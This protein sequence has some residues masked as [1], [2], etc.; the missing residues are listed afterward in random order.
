MG[1]FTGPSKSISFQ[2]GSGNN[3]NDLGSG[4]LTANSGPGAVMNEAGQR[5]DLWSVHKSG[6]TNFRD[7]PPYYVM[8][9]ATLLM[10]FRW[11]TVR[12]SRGISAGHT[13][14]HHISPPPSYFLAETSNASVTFFE[15]DEDAHQEPV[16]S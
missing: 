5:S 8:S 7:F 6:S 14:G 10:A 4:V 3:A 1:T 13:S 12:H 11:I 16:T 2:K 9:A 15:E